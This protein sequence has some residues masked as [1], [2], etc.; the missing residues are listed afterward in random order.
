MV[1]YIGTEKWIQSLDL[2]VESTWSPWFVEHEVSGFVSILSCYGL[3][4]GTYLE[5]KQQQ[6]MFPMP[7]ILFYKNILFEI[8]VLFNMYDFKSIDHL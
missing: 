8:N 5:F 2:K 1:P 3:Q 6:N 7:N 4:W